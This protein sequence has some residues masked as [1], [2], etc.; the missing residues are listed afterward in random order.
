MKFT[1]SSQP[2]TP[3]NLYREY[4]VS[5]EEG[6][7]SSIAP[8]VLSTLIDYVFKVILGLTVSQSVSQSVS[9]CRAPSGSHDHMF[10]A[11]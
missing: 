5:P 3:E 1:S 11:A 4:S 2:H 7:R 9:W 6:C 8:E 10:V